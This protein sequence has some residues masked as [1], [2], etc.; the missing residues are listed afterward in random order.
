MRECRLSAQASFTIGSQAIGPV[1]VAF[2]V[3]GRINVAKVDRFIFNLLPKDVE[4]IAVIE[5]K[6]V[7]AASSGSHGND[8]GFL[9]QR[10]ADGG[11]AS[12]LPR[13]SIRRAL[14]AEIRFSSFVA[15]AQSYDP[16]RTQLTDDHVL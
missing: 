4:V 12:G 5:S 9:L 13:R 14:A 3:E 1:V 11:E 16:T 8:K 2:R 7:L 15:K 10:R 6:A